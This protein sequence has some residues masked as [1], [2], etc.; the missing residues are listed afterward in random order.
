[1]PS[2]STPSPVPYPPGLE[3]NSPTA[4]CKT[5]ALLSPFPLAAPGT[6]PTVSLFPSQRLL[7]DNRPH[8]RIF[9]GIGRADGPGVPPITAGCGGRVVGAS[10]RRRGKG[11][12]GHSDP[13]GCRRV[14]P[15]GGGVPAN[16]RP[17]LRIGPP[18]S[19]CGSGP[20]L[21]SKP[22]LL[23]LSGAGLQTGCPVREVILAA[24]RTSLRFCWCTLAE[25]CL[26]SSV[27]EARGGHAAPR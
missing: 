16:T 23:S 7:R 17:R 4:R 21:S 3:S 9:G 18:G 10:R 27:P 2:V 5:S 26:V 14:Y 12:H 8:L 13:R 20:V 6:I 24:Q 1:M 15:R 25:G 22:F 11:G 19:W